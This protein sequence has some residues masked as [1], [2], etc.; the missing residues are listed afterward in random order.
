APRGEPGGGADHRHRRGR[1]GRAV[2]DGEPVDRPPDEDP[3]SERRRREP[4]LSARSR[5]GAGANTR[6]P[7]GHAVTAGAR[8]PAV[9][10]AG[11]VKRYGDVT[12][13]AGL[14]L[15]VRAGECFGL[16]RPNGAGKTTTVETL[17]GLTSGDSGIVEV[18]GQ[19][20]AGGAA[21]RRLRERLGI[22][23]QETKLPEK[24]SVEE[25]IRL[26]ES[27]YREPPGL[28]E[29]LAQVELGEKRRAW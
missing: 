12:A 15:E 1:R 18:L 27:F 22:Q 6:G 20:W 7:E 23:L 29:V 17:D 10:C 21:G 11:L 19:S 2:D 5:P 24:L 8:P 25:T 3:R 16:L 28:E 9:R 26:F 4:H 14:D 13:V